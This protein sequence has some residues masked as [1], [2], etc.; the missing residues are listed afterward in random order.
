MGAISC[1]LIQTAKAASEATEGI[2]LL[3]GW[4]LTLPGWRYLILCAVAA[5]GIRVLTSALKVPAIKY[6]QYSQWLTE[7]EEDPQQWSLCK[8]WWRAFWPFG[9]HRLADLG[10][11]FIIGFAEIAAYPVLLHRE[12]FAIIGGWLALKTAGHWG[13]WKGSR[14]SVNRFLIANLLNLAVSYFWLLSYVEPVVPRGTP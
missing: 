1:L 4:R 3:E 2:S 9:K 11:G 6:G 12:A 7:D 13:A 8:A 10:Y 14:T 5:V